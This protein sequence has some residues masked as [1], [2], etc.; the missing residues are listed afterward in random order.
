MDIKKIA[1]RC[2]Q[3]LDMRDIKLSEEYFYQSLPLCVIDAVYSLG[4]RYQST[5][6]VVIR[7]CNYFNLQRIR[8]NKNS[9]PSKETQE[10][11]ENFVEK[12]R[13]I[14]VEKFANEIFRNRQ[15]TSPKGGIP[16]A[17]AVL[18]FA[19]VLKK[20]NINYIQD[21]PAIISNSNFEK[22][23]KNI[24]GQK[25][26]ISLKYFFMLSGSD[27][28][29]KPDRW[30]LK[31]LTDTLLRNVTSEETEF[32]LRG[33]SEKLKLKYPNITPRLLDYLIWNYKKQG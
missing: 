5:R 20:Y 24:P 25:S 13:R 19:T 29:V 9:L 31:F 18:R 11:I 23:I 15:K 33:V 6:Q 21:V 1:N 12:M 17:E 14:G 7:Y 26:G 2:E 22:D 30:I 10:S 16:K 4:A 3:L 27:D 32:L 8:E 28:F